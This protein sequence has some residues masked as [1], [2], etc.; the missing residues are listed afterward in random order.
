[1]FICART[2]LGLRGYRA[3]LLDDPV[4]MDQQLPGR[5]FR[6]RTSSTCCVAR[7]LRGSN[8]RAVRNYRRPV[9]PQPP[10]PRAV[11]S[12]VRDH[13]PLDVLHALLNDELRDPV[14]AAYVE[15]G[16]GIKIDQQDADLVAVAGVDQAGRVQARDPVAQSTVPI[17]AARIRRS[18]LER[19]PSAKPV[20]PRA[21]PAAAS[22]ASSQAQ[23]IARVALITARRSGRSGS[24]AP[25]ADAHGRRLVSTRRAGRRAAPRCCSLRQHHVV[26]VLRMVDDDVDG[27]AREHLDVVR[28]E[29]ELQEVHGRGRVVAREARSRP[30]RRAGP[31]PGAVGQHNG[32]C[33]RCRRDAATIPAA[34]F[35][36]ELEHQRARQLAGVGDDLVVGLDLV[37]IC[38]SRSIRSSAPSPAPASASCRCS[39]TRSS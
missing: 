13:V 3:G 31:A 5:G 15:R 17:A 35:R 6:S 30:R 20:F 10:T 39:R 26:V 29:R 32:R 7:R 12:R 36:R 18:P 4:E 27:S 19:S 38:S 11:S 1:M 2:V 25:D 9:E 37:A 8:C 16:G 21:R 28:R 22:R 34:P 23:V 14:T 33:A 24:S